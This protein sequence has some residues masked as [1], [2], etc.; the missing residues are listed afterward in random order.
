M[1]WILDNKMLIISILLNIVGAFDRIATKTPED[2]KIFG[3]KVG[4]YDDEI[5]KALG[6]LRDIIVS[7][8]PTKK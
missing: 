7:F 2:F 4:K 6:Y 3:I 5:A 1:E 8:F